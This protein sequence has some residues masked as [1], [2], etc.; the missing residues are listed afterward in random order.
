MTTDRPRLLDVLYRS[1]TKQDVKQVL[2]GWLK[3]WGVLT[4]LI[5]GMILLTLFTLMVHELVAETAL[6]EDP[7]VLGAIKWALNMPAFAVLAATGAYTYNTV[8]EFIGAGET[9]QWT[10]TTLAL[11]GVL[12]L[13]SFIVWVAMPIAS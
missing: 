4:L 5:S 2:Q 8:G 7:V 12:G 1:P 6:S 11:C 13:A 10:P 9:G 3:L